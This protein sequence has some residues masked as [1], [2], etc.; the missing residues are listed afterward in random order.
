MPRRLLAIIGI[1]SAFIARA[2]MSLAC[3][4]PSVASA[5]FLVIVGTVMVLAL[6]VSADGSAEREGPRAGWAVGCMVFVSV[7]A[8]VLLGY[9]CPVLDA[10]LADDLEQRFADLTSPIGE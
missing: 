2:E 10:F 7:F 4:A 5:F 1:Y 3:N 8:V 6:T 9:G